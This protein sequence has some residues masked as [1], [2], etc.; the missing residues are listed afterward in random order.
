MT[1]A[2]ES[3]SVVFDLN[4]PV[5]HAD[6]YPTYARMRAEA[7]VY[8]QEPFGVYWLFRHADCDEALRNPALGSPWGSPESI[9]QKLGDGP[10]ACYVGKAMLA[11]DPPEHTRLRRAVARAF[12][13]RA[14]EA[15]R[16]RVVDKVN[17]LLDEVTAGGR[18]E[19][20]LANEVAYRVPIGIVCELIGV[21]PEHHDR[22]RS[23]I[24]ENAAV[25][26]PLPTP[27][28]VAM[29]DKASG[30]LMDFVAA[31]AAERRAEPRDDLMSALVAP[32]GEAPSLTDEELV[33][34]VA[35]LIAAGFC[36]TMQLIGN[37][38]LLLLRHPEQLEMVWTN[39]AMAPGAIE[40]T[41]RYEPPVMMWP[42]NVAADVEIGGVLLP[43]GAPVVS[44]I[45]AANRDPDVFENPDVF[46]I[47]RPAPPHLT[48][49]GPIHYCLGASLA[50]MESQV[51]LVT[52]LSRFPDLAL[53]SEKVEWLENNTVRGLKELRVTTGS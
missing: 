28:Q 15:M 48:F 5:M 11:H 26:E 16:P 23:L 17:R 32:D 45:G 18:R 35:L 1:T 39:P 43:A 41:L 9:A 49:G 29:A 44:V 36:S 47:T 3:G 53:A 31:L 20:D 42:R 40:E 38:V 33:A 7:P 22:F 30:E 10:A 13:P 27:E 2:M 8:R 46:D 25:I 21:A 24:E 4:D 37:S 14:V 34:N 6:P 19:F 51:A 52:I 12:T 50:R